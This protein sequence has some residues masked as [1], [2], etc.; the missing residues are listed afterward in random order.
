MNQKAAFVDE[1]LGYCLSRSGAAAAQ[2]AH[3]LHL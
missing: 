3:F 1:E 2:L